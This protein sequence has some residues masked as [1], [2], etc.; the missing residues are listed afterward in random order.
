MSGFS[1]IRKNVGHDFN[2]FT[3]VTVTWSA[4]GGSSADG[5]S[6]D[7]IIPFPTQGLMLLN[8]DS[9]NIVEVSFNGNTLHDELNPAQPSKGIAYDNRVNSL[10]WLR[11]K[12][13]SA[14]PAIVSVR[15][16]GVR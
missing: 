14:G 16:W 12:T 10:V 6:P 4:F 3:K 11:L 13:G 1:G 15:A 2:Y 7:L 9:T 5:S 8:E